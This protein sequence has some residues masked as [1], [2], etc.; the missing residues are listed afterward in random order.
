MSPDPFAIRMPPDI[1]SVRVG[2][3]PVVVIDDFL[4]HP[5]ALVEAACQ[6]RF[7][8]CPGADER[9]GYPGLRAPVPAAYSESLTELLDP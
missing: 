6:A 4:A 3:H 5:Q 1:R 9:K 8:R 2:E 7:E